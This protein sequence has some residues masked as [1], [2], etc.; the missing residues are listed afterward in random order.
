MKR[1]LLFIFLLNFVIA[2]GLHS[3]IVG[4]APQLFNSQ[5]QGS[6]IPGMQLKKSVQNLQDSS[7]GPESKIFNIDCTTLEFKEASSGEKFDLNLGLEFSYVFKHFFGNPY[8]QEYFDIEKVEEGWVR[9]KRKESSKSKTPLADQQVRFTGDGSTLLMV[10]SHL[11]QSNW[12]YDL[13]ITITVHFDKSGQY[14]HHDIHVFTDVLGSGPTE[15]FIKAR[16]IL[17]NP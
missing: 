13:D 9:A 12:L 5:I 17:P 10:E 16:A 15:S 1:N 8:I 6:C 7:Q 4:T 3:Q 2:A 11:L 14:T